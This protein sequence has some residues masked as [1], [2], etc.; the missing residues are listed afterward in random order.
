MKRGHG[1]AIGAGALGTLAAFVAPLQQGLL[2]VYFFLLGSL[3][4]GIWFW[5]RVFK[6]NAAPQVTAKRKRRAP[7]SSSSG[8]GKLPCKGTSTD[9]AGYPAVDPNAKPASPRVAALHCRTESHSRGSSVAR[10]SENSESYRSGSDVSGV[11]EAHATLGLPP[12][13]TREGELWDEGSFDSADEADSEAE[14]DCLLPGAE[15]RRRLPRRMSFSSLNLAVGCFPPR[16]NVKHHVVSACLYAQ[17]L[18]ST[19]AVQR[20]VETR[21]LKFHRFSS[22]PVVSFLYPR[23]REVS[24]HPGAHVRRLRVRGIAELHLCTEWIMCQPCDPERPRWQIWLIENTAVQAQQRG[25]DDEEQSRELVED[26]NSEDYRT[27]EERAGAESRV[28]LRGAP[29]HC[30]MIRAEHCIGD[31]ISLIELGLRLLTDAQGLPLNEWTEPPIL[32]GPATAAAEHLCHLPSPTAHL[33]RWTK[34]LLK[35]PR[36][37]AEALWVGAL[38]FRGALRT[39]VAA[40]VNKR[41]ACTPMTGSAEHRN[42]LLWCE[43]AQVA[44]ASPLSL[45]FVRAIKKEA[46]ATLNDVFVAAFTGAMKRYC[47]LQGDEQFSHGAGVTLPKMLVACAFFRRTKELPDSSQLLLRNRFTLTSL[48]LPADAADARERLS[49]VQQAT[50]SLKRSRQPAADFLCQKVL[51]QLLPTPLTRQAAEGLFSTHSVVFSN[52]PAYTAPVH[53]CGCKIT[54]VQVLYPNLIPQV[55]VVSYAGRIFL[56]FVYDPSVVTEGHKI[57]HLFAEELLRL[58]DAYGVR[59]PEDE[60]QQEGQEDLMKTAQQAANGS[61]SPSTTNGSSNSSI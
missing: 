53:F 1:A 58:A 55:E 18:P 11:S 22:V 2:W 47:E 61:S 38:L 8:R 7:R 16:S 9:A 50:T 52:L 31:G 25:N 54:E 12:P 51:G 28:G 35:A 36:R 44:S 5:G 42:R 37:L 32:K 60:H 48:T 19:Q 34:V 10:E 59:R 13:T 15:H 29:R 4:Y 57:P 39:I 14:Q 21:L 49:R 27:P 24:V 23:W 46:N 41:D 30:I 20:L 26:W 45:Q 40:I 56:S 3:V 33:L 43:R 17:S 6:H